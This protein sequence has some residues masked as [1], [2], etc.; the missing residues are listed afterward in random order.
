MKSV[1]QISSI[2]VVVLSVGCLSCAPQPPV[3]LGR[4]PSGVSAKDFPK[5]FKEWSREIRVIPFNG[6]DNILTARVTYLSY[7]FREA[8]VEALTADLNSSASDK[9]QIRAEQFSGLDTGHQ[10]F[11]SLMSAVKNCDNL[12]PED[13]PWTIRLQNDQGK[14]VSPSAVE[15]IEKPTPAHVKYFAFNPSYRKAYKITFPLTAADG[16]PILG[17]N[18]RAFEVIFANPYGRGVARWEIAGR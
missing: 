5:R 15:E 13:G 18:T 16:A 1:T 4:R 10:F 8:Y 9:A 2:L 11:V 17:D 14:E 12:D 6:L 3:D 7:R